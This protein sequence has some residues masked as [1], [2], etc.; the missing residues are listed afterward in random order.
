MRSGGT[1]SSTT[2]RSVKHGPRRF[3]RG[4]R[5]FS[6]HPAMATVTAA[7]ASDHC[8]ILETAGGGPPAFLPCPDALHA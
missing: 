6:A 4:D 5:L 1:F 2:S 3:A 7:S 8:A